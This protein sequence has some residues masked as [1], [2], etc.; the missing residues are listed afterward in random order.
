MVFG[1]CLWKCDST[2]PTPETSINM[3]HGHMCVEKLFYQGKNRQ[4]SINTFWRTATKSCYGVR[5]TI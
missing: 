1:P 4:K 3:S 5:N 2:D